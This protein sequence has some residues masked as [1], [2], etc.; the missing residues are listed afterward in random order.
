ML[1]LPYSAAAFF[2]LTSFGLSQTA[3]GFGVDL[4]GNQISDLFEQQYPGAG[5]PNG[6]SDADGQTNK[7]EA[8]SGTNPL[9]GRSRLDFSDITTTPATVNAQWP[10][11]LGKRYQLQMSE[12]LSGGWTN[13]GTATMGTGGTINGV[14]PL[15]GNRV[16]LRLQ[17]QDVDSD[18]D[19]VSDWEEILAGTDSE[20]ADSD[21]D[22]I[23]DYDAVSRHTVVS[24]LVS[25][26]AVDSRGTEAGDPIQFK[27]VRSGNY[28]PISVSLGYAGTAS[29]GTDYTAGPSSV[30]LGLGENSAIV[31]LTPLPDAVVE[32]G[33]ETVVLNALPGAGYSV[34]SL[35][36]A[37]ATISETNGGVGLTGRYFNDPTSATNAYNSSDPYTSGGHFNPATLIETRLDPMIAFD[38]GTGRPYNTALGG[39]DDYHSVVWT[40]QIE[41]PNTEAYT[42]YVQC[43]GGS[44]LWING[45]LV[46]FVNGSN[47]AYTADQVWNGVSSTEVRSLPINL[48]AGQKYDIKMEWHDETGSSSANLRWQTATIAK[49]TVPSTRLYPAPMTPVL[50]EPIFAVAFVGGPFIY[51]ISAAN[52]PIISYGVDGLPAGLTVNPATG[53]ITGS[54]TAAAGLYFPIITATSATGTGCATMSLLV[55]SN[56]GGLT[57]DVWTGVTGRLV[58]LPLHTAPT[59]SS[60]TSSL[61]APPDTGDDYGDRLRGYLTAPT[62]GNY[63]FF[64]SSD[65]NAELWISSS[66]DPGQTLKRSWV[67]NGAGISPGAWNVA[68][69]QRSLSVKLQAGQQYY[70]EVRRRETGGSDHLQV[71]W[72][73][74]GQ[75]GSDPSEV[76]PGWALSP[77]IPPSATTTD[78]TLYSA[79]LTP[80][81]GVMSLGSGSA[82]LR[83]NADK[84]AA[85]LAFT[86]SNLTG[87][88]VSQHIHDARSLP[89]PV[90]AIVFDIDTEEPDVNGVRH[91]TLT[92]TGNHSIQDI[93]DAIEVGQAYINLHTNAYPNGEIK[94]FFQPVNGSQNFVPPAAPPAAE[95]ALPGDPAFRKL[96]IVRF[97]Q[98]ATF[99]AAPDRDGVTDANPANTPFSGWQPDSIEAVDSLG[100]AAWIDAQM[101]MSPGPDPETMTPQVVPPTTVYQ[102]PSTSRRSPNLPVTV[103]DGAGP[104]MTFL[105]EHTT[106]YPQSGPEPNGALV[107]N[108]ED[109]WRTWWRQSCTAPDQLRQRVAFALSQILVVS[110][111]GE[112]D[113]RTRAVLQYY[114]VLYYHSF[115]NFRTLLERITLNP[116]MGRYLDMYGNKKPN[117]TTG[118][119][120]NENYAR[121]ILQ[122]FSVGLKR[123]HPDGTT[124]L[125]NAGLPLVTY[126]QP[127]VVGFAHTFTGWS[128]RGTGGGSNYVTPMSPLASDHDLGEK[129]LLERTYLEANGAPTTQTCNDNLKGALDCIFHHPNVGP[130]ISRQLIQ[131]MVTANPSPGYIYRVSKVFE[132]NGAGVRGDMGAVVKA[133]LLDSEARNFAPRGNPGYGHL[134]EPL[135]RATQVLRAFRCFSYA[136]TYF[137]TENQLGVAVYSPTNNVDLSQPLPT[138]TINYTSP[139]A[140]ITYS[141][142]YETVDPDGAT[143]ATFGPT[144]YKFVMTPG[145]LLLLRRQTNGSTAADSQGNTNSPENGVYVFTDSA[146]PLTRWTGADEPAELNNAF[147]LVSTSRRDAPDS[148][149]GT[150]GTNG[151]GLGGNRWFKQ[152]LPV[153]TVGVSPIQWTVD[154]AGSRLRYRWQMGG[155][156]S[157]SF[158]QTPLKSP[159]VFNFFEP[160]YVFLGDTG[161]AGLYGPEFQITSETSVVNTANWFYELTRLNDQTITTATY[162]QGFSYGNPY[163]KEI[164]LDTIGEQTPA[165]DAGTL[166]DHLSGMLMPHQMPPRLRTLLVDY[167]N[168]M[169]ET[170]LTAGTSWKY[171]TDAAGLGASNIVVGHASYNTSN[172]KHPDFDDSAWSTG[173]AQLGYGENDE[174]TVLPFGG[175]ASSKWLTS[176]FRKE[177]NATGLAGIGT[178]TVRIKR[179]DGA[180]VYI[181]GKEAFRS[182]MTTGTVY[183]GTSTAPSGASD[184]GQNFNDVVVPVSF[185][186]EGRNVIAVEL[187]QSAANSSD[188][189]FDLAIQDVRNGATPATQLTTSDRMLRIGEALFLISLSPEFAVQK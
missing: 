149:G 92:P 153:A 114:D 111:D 73:R 180:I 107:E 160:D 115:G 75:A 151:G 132:D 94:G 120:P 141:F 124:V 117:T 74:P 46:T 139:T 50:K 97:L 57:R 81:N 80:Q 56:G 30:Y 110:E 188:L 76:I 44:R 34:G 82:T 122:L 137:N 167:L 182:N 126:E 71:G 164:K 21:N 67:T 28:N 138:E 113:E 95:L 145:N 109:I 88:I 68:T 176:Y 177:F 133:L 144:Q 173:N 45:Q 131:R 134:K 181:N 11:V 18:G 127:N 179:D 118:Y 163:K 98:Q 54:P 77:Y 148:P 172:W 143:G 41:A 32:V 8:A 3:P 6:D 130:F 186:V 42:F 155:T 70:V 58:D 14:C 100:Y 60:L 69:T 89:G 170:L 154:S 10:S 86:F 152:T 72:L 90:E 15:Q 78:G 99:G 19:G 175:N 169:P 174:A 147:L 62:S 83:V 105:K 51:Q 22:G 104:A 150:V 29:S 171:F 108:S 2:L 156:G 96:E 106:E 84:T 79:T 187:H 40:G 162:G 9:D 136:E 103:Y 185:L 59:S 36:A 16:F 159:T 5:D 43:N 47:Q 27:V 49:A 129:L 33:G 55:I 102:E 87:P 25:V 125:S 184:D 157:G 61:A 168:T 31:T 128:S 121:E 178:L 26:V 64:V 20:S 23:R 48:Q 24:S 1:C 189:S 165:E 93:I 146:Q 116:A 140:S 183:T 91:W 63:V 158:Q 66:S 65:E 4:N 112:L 119:I 101:A 142:I 13:E 38:W 17:V 161:N 53:Q 123:L 135:L 37:S 52:G 166:V 85:E 7:Q 35:N 12:S 39:D